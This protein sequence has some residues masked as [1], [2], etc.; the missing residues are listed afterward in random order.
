MAVIGEYAD[1][2][3]GV[4]ISWKSNT[5]ALID[6]VDGPQAKRA[7][8]DKTHS[9]SPE[10]WKEFIPGLKENDQL[11]CKINFDPN[12]PE[13]F[14]VDTND[15]TDTLIITF[16]VKVGETTGATMTTSAFMMECSVAVP[17]EDRMTQDVVWKLTGKPTWAPGA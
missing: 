8:V 4:Q 14:P 15:A 11:A 2:G 17:L 6:T 3:W 9:L 12:T 16:P 5:Y 10:E 1:I 13:V 7:S